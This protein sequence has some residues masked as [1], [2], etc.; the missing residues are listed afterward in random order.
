MRYK[1]MAIRFAAMLLTCL[2]AAQASAETRVVMLGTGTPVPDADRAGQSVAVVYNN[3][4]Y[5]FDLGGGAVQNAISAA[6]NK[7]IKALSPTRINHVFFTHL[8]SD[9]I[10]DYPELLAA[11]WWRRENRMHVYGPP[12]TKAMSQG[13]YDFLAPDVR[14]RMIGNQ[15][16]ADEE[17]YKAR[18][19]EFSEGGT[20]L[21]KPGIRVEA[22]SIS[23][24]A[25]ERAF[26]YKITT[27]D[28]TIVISGDTAYDP[29]IAK[30]AEGADILIHEVISEAGLS[31][32][33]DFWQNYHHAAH[34]T[35]TE[36]AKLARQ[37]QPGLVVLVHN[38]FYGAPETST[39][40][41][42]RAVYDGEVVLADDLDVY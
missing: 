40:R 36:V 30:Q 17:G 29:A 18:V 39:L 4:A 27:S 42:V 16:I 13:V 3:E 34:T 10:E 6:Q 5:V 11:Y 37:A 12:G 32:L 22:F 19:T 24:G 1:M 2:L 9:H 14:A 38:L 15:P 28:E 31:E 21:E 8:H 35:S 7:G 33:S 25:L 41:E 23:H 26:G 20:V